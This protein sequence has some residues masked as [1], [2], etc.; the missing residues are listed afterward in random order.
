MA[1][2]DMVGEV[3]ADLMDQ[4]IRQ[5]NLK[6]LILGSEDVLFNDSDD[7][8]EGSEVDHILSVL[9]EIFEEL[10]EVLF[11]SL[12]LGSDKSF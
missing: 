3:L 1:W 8:P 2:L 10:D 12:A 6:C 11:D 5:G 4:K 7:F 9:I